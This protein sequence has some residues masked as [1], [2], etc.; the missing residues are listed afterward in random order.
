MVWLR[1]VGDAAIGEQEGCCQ[2]GC[3]FFHRRRVPGPL[4]L[5][6]DRADE[7]RRWR[8]QTRD[9]GWRKSRGRWASQQFGMCMR[10]SPV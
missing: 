10:S 8:G 4:P 5:K 7:L 2:P 6:P 9:F 1:F 3:C